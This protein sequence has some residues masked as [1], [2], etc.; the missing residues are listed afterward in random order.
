MLVV[1]GILEYQLKSG[2]PSK[3]C[4]VISGRNHKDYDT[5]DKLPSKI[6]VP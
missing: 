2:A 3:F 1:T 4:L 5:Y 6:P